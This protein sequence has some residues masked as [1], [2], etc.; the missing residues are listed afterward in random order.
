M[1]VPARTN[2]VLIAFHLTNS[3]RPYRMNYKWR[4]L[5]PS[6]SQTC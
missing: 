6:R 2:R 3:L 5:H 1:L 4:L